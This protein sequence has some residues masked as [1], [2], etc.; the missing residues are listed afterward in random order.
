MEY[1]HITLHNNSSLTLNNSKSCN[2]TI[3]SLQKKTLRKIQINTSSQLIKYIKRGR[4]T[5]DLFNYL[6]L[7]LA[8]SSS[9]HGSCFNLDFKNRIQKCWSDHGGGVVDYF[10]HDSLHRDAFVI[11]SGL[12]YWDG[13]RKLWNF[14]LFSALYFYFFAF[15]I[16]FLVY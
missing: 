11:S 16:N 3:K 13:G 4:G 12:V 6:G 9:D 5:N 7:L 1:H 15:A 14:Y 10:P 2:I 8:L